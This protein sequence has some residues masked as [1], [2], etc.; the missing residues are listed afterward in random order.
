MADSDEESSSGHDPF[1]LEALWQLVERVDSAPAADP[2]IGTSIGGIEILRLI[3][4]GGMGRVYEGRQ[5]SPG[6]LVAVKLLRPGPSARATIR[7]FLQEAQILGQL[8]HPWICQ[9]HAAGTFDFA[10]AQLPYFVMELIPDGL[11]ITE[12]A[13]RHNLTQADRLALFGQICDAVGHAHA[14]GVVHRDLKPGNVLVDAAGH[15]R[16]IDFGI[17]RGDP[18]ATDLPSMTLTATGH[19][20]GTI[21]YMSPEQVEGSASAVDARADVYALGVILHE[22]V[23]GTPPYDLTELPLLDA[24]RIIRESRPPLIRPC[25][26]ATARVSLVIDRCLEKDPRKRYADAGALAA[27]VRRGADDRRL[28]IVDRARMIT[29][30]IDRPGRRLRWAAATVAAG[31]VVA[32]ALGSRPWGDGS[33]AGRDGLVGGSRTA[34][35]VPVP[36]RAAATLPFR[37]SFTS[38]L[39]E[40]ADRYLVTAENMR[41][42]NDPREELRVNYWGPSGNDQVGTLVFRFPF[43]GRSARISIETVLECWDFEKH[44][45]GFGRGACA[46]E[47]SRDGTSWTSLRDDIR[48]GRWG[49][50]VTLSGELPADLLGSDVLWLRLRLLTTRAEPKAGYT[51]AQF[52]RAIPGTGREVFVIEA[53]CAPSDSPH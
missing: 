19:L 13:R 5:D 14:Q 48:D 26:A 34:A 23:A 10:G 29:R 43:P 32:M 35:A 52:A 31:A 50:N 24:M 53:D 8:R 45:G 21:Q 49:T 36:T 3:A 17:A 15:P 2:L 40:E 27:E 18:A 46:V 47:V 42:W 1:G 25:D 11:A 16:V 12:Y 4:E 22:L 41:K 37:Y 30:W 51:V 39:D 28:A 7:R 20:L 33:A 6:R 44:H 9:V 38:V